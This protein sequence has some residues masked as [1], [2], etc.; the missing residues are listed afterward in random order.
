MP[1]L[2]GGPAPACPIPPVIRVV[3]LHTEAVDKD[4][5][6]ETVRTFDFTKKKILNIFYSS[7]QFGW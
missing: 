1:A 4:L 5:C 7:L 6:P 2:Q 3:L